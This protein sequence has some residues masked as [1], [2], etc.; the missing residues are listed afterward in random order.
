MQ[1]TR[2]FSYTKVM[3]SQASQLPQEVASGLAV[4]FFQESRH[5]FF[6]LFVA[7]A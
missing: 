1:A 6:G 5:F 7:R 3:L 2:S 4:E